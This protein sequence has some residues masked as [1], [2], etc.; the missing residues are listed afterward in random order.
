MLFLDICKADGAFAYKD[1]ELYH[2]VVYN[3]EHHY[4]FS[5]AALFM[6]QGVSQCYPALCCLNIFTA[7]FSEAVTLPRLVLCLRF[8]L[9]L[10]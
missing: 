3:Q 10:T 6:L 9:G 8:S 4:L 7:Y 2:V 1:Y 5:V